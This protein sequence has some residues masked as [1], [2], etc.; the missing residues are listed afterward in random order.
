MFVVDQTAAAALAAGCV[1]VFIIL[2][3]FLI[4]VSNAIPTL[5]RHV[6]IIRP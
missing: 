2:S 3:L 5:G 1:C 6:I 4:S